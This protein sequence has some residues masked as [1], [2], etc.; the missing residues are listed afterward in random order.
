SPRLVFIM[1]IACTPSTRRTPD[2]TLVLA[3]ETPMTTSDPRYALTNYDEKLGKLIA[4]GLTTVDTPTAE[5]ELL[6]AAK[7]EHT[8]ELTID[9][10]LRADARFSDGSPVTADDIARTYMTVMDP[11]CGSLFQKNLDE[12]FVRVAAVND[13]VVR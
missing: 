13:H 1:L 10:S 5:P 2:D 7:I 11:K 3:I 12:R 8:D 6:L 4:P 9:I